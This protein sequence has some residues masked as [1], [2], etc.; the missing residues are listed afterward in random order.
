MS[1]TIQHRSKT[2][3]SVL[4]DFGQITQS[5]RLSVV[6]QITQKVS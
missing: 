6:G 3:H 4:S 2:V 5:A 1:W